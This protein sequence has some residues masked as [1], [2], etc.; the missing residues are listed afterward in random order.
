[1]EVRIPSSTSL[2]YRAHRQRSLEPTLQP[3]PR[4]ACAALGAAG[5]P[6]EYLQYGS[7]LPG[8]WRRRNALK[9]WTGWGTFPMVW[10]EGTLVGG[11]SD[12]KKLL[13]GGE[14]DHLK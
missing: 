12:L 7:Y 8:E 14:L 1:M 11:Y 9:M 4:R 3:F 5:I 6:Y 10:V 13:D 2:S